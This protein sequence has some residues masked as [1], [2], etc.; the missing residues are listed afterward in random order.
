MTRWYKESC[1]RDLMR[2]RMMM[3][4]M[5]M[6]S[7]AKSLTLYMLMAWLIKWWRRLLQVHVG[8]QFPHKFENIR[9]MT[10][11]QEFFRKVPTSIFDPDL[12]V[13]WVDFS[14]DDLL[15]WCRYFLHS[16]QHRR[17]QLVLM[18]RNILPPP[19]FRY[20]LHH[21]GVEDRGVSCS[22]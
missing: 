5:M 16:L 1:R 12:H 11:W 18:I 8:Y 3:R 20:L 13:G 9:M 19:G 21:L 10:F 7:G 14:S 22:H 15:S 17:R 2:K 6:S 4:L